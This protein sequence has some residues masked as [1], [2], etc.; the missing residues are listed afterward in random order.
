MTLRDAALRLGFHD[1]RFGAQRMAQDRLIAGILDGSILLWPYSRDESLTAIT[2]L[3]NAP[4]AAT[5]AALLDE[6]MP[7]LAELQGHIER[8]IAWRKGL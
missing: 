4:D 2:A 7:A 6:A 5:R 3:V 1:E 8:T